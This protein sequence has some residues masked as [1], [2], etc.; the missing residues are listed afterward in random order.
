MRLPALFILSALAFAAAAAAAPAPRFVEVR[1]IAVND[2]HGNL[3]P[4]ARTDGDREAGA[5]AL[6]ATLAGLRA[7]Q[8]HSLFV[9]AGDLIG[10]SPLPSALAHDEP[11]LKLFGLLGLQA[12]AIGN[13]ELDGGLLE[14]QRQQA[15][16]GYPFLS[17]NLVAIADGKPVFP[18]YRLIE[19]EGVRV[20]LV[21]A[22]ARNSLKPLE[23]D[24]VPGLRLD[25]EAQ[26]INAQVSIL[27]AQGVRAI[28]V[29]LH[30]GAELQGTVNESDCHG[31]QGPARDIAAKIDP[32]V[33]LVLSAHSHRLYACR[34]DGR[35]LTQA[36]ANGRYVTVAD[37]RIDRDSGDVVATK[38]DNQRVLAAA[39]TVP[40][41]RVTGLVDDAVAAADKIAKAP[42]AR[43]SGASVSAAPDHDGGSPL[44][45][46]VARAQ[47]AAASSLGAELACTNPSSVPRDLVAS[48][49]GNL[50]TYADVRDTQP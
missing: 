5:V 29:L 47:L 13:H 12:D 7:G 17:A 49:Q 11:T 46:L 24:L 44:G 31:L 30:E 18:A 3:E 20:A 34:L 22:T 40:D 43:L 25:D 15:L 9:S 45:R 36:G 50:V 23:P 26:A 37:L 48:Q 33:D 1:V 21:G 39:R 32:E 41:A 28:I 8:P 2:F 14:L 19:V 42:V 16:V 27:R 38:I 4:L 10:A 35:W 6:A